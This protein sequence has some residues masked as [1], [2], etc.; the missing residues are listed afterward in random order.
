MVAFSS[1]QDFFQ[2]F[3]LYFLLPFPSQN[4]LTRLND[5][6]Y[7]ML[8]YLAYGNGARIFRLLLRQI[9]IPSLTDTTS[10]LFS[11]QVMALPQ[12]QK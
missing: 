5:H 9:L 3:L 12:R 6:S 11:A 4:T 10:H 8:L 7:S 1:H 2:L